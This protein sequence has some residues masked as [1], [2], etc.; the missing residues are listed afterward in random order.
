M[1]GKAVR[2][3]WKVA[4]TSETWA[5]ARRYSREEIR[6]KIH[7]AMTM[8]GTKAKTMA[9]SVRSVAKSMTVMPTSI[10]TDAIV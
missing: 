8:A 7:V 1:V 6:R 9:V 10:V 4:L 5:R 2:A 3:S